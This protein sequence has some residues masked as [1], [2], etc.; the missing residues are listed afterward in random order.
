[1]IKRSGKTKKA[2]LIAAIIILCFV[3]C[4]FAVVQ[5]VRLFSDSGDK[6]DM[7]FEG[8]EVIGTELL[9]YVNYNSYGQDFEIGRDITVAADPNFENI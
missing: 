8:A 3:L 7:R 4:A 9:L 5:I 1:M 6:I 2:L